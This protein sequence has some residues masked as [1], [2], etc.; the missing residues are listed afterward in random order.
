[1]EDEEKTLIEKVRDF[2]DDT[3]LFEHSLAV[4]KKAHE[5]ALQYHENPEK[6]FTAGLLH[7]VGG[8]YPSEKRVI[9]ADEAGINLLPEEREVPLLIHQKLSKFLARW[10]FG[11]FN[12]EILDAIE[13]HTTLRADF[14]KLDLLVFLADKIAWDGGNHAPLKKGLLEHL[15]QSPEAAALYYI[16]FSLQNGLLIVHPWL[17]EAKKTLEKLS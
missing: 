12:D 2:L 7:D 1:M 10:E 4:A 14:T 8:I 16:N 17:L 9:I 11:I 13:C 15:K 6:A 5:L 3:V